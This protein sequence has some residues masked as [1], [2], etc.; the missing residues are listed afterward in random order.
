LAAKDEDCMTECRLEVHTEPEKALV[1]YGGWQAPAMDSTALLIFS[2]NSQGSKSSTIQPA[3]NYNNKQPI[4]AQSTIL[5]SRCSDHMYHPVLSN[6]W[7]KITRL[8]I[9]PSTE[10]DAG[11]GSATHKEPTQAPSADSTENQAS[12]HGCHQP[13]LIPCQPIM[14]GQPIKKDTCLHLQEA[15]ILEN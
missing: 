10:W 6:L 2:P 3:Y 11:G 12:K 4:N 15:Y 7:M 14:S 1:I 5:L 13:T 8:S 9:D